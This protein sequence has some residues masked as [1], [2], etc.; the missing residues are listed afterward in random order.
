MLVMVAASVRL[1]LVAHIVL[2]EAPLSVVPLLVFP[3]VPLLGAQGGVKEGLGVNVLK[4]VEVS[5]GVLVFVKVMVGDGVWVK[6][7][8]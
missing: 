1:Y 3:K 6:L 5:I 7:G 2:S 4:G 8:V